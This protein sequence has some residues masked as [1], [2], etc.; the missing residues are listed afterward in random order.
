M[1]VSLVKLNNSFLSVLNHS[2]LTYQSYSCDQV[3]LYVL[4]AIISPNELVCHTLNL[5]ASL[6]SYSK[7]ILL[8]SKK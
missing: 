4:L 3:D 2:V 1:L 7:L 6:F 8:Y 5:D